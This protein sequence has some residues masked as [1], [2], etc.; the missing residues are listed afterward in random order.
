[1]WGLK[2]KLSNAPKTLINLFAEY[3]TTPM[4]HK[5]F[6]PP[7]FSSLSHFRFWRSSFPEIFK[8]R[9]RP[10]TLNRW[11]LAGSDQSGTRETSLYEK[12]EKNYYDKIGQVGIS[13]ESVTGRGQMVENFTERHE[14]LPG[15][16]GMHV[17]WWSTTQM[18]TNEWK[19]L[20]QTGHLN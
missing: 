6:H 3:T 8:G 11:H 2:L 5:N 1:M 16:L 9:C 19:S 7:I 4:K 17:I 12:S 13:L 20:R 14:R 18:T 10:G 15:H